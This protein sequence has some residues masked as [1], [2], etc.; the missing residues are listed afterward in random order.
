MDIGD[1]R[2]SQIPR[3]LLRWNFDV[4]SAC[5]GVFDSDGSKRSGDGQTFIKNSISYGKI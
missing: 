1:C 3:S 5:R 2:E 4:P